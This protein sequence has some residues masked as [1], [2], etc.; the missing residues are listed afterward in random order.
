MKTISFTVLM[1]TITVILFSSCAAQSRV[2][3]AER[4]PAP[5]VMR[6]A[7]PFAGAI[8]VGPEYRWH[9]GQYVYV[10]PRYVTPRHG[11]TWAQGYWK[12]HH[13]KQ[14]WVKGHWRR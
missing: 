2:Y 14:V 5:V 12:H 3:V 1:A 10:A 6:P 7:P 13:G 4:H 11:H 9:R 8:W